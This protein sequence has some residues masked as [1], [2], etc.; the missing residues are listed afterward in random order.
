MKKDIIVAGTGCAGLI[1]ALA[2]ERKGAEVLLVD[3]GPL[4]IGSNSA[5][6]NGVF[7]GLG[8]TYTA[9]TYARDTIEIGKEINNPAYVD[10]VAK[11]ILPAIDVLRSHGVIVEESD[12]VFVVRP[13]RRDLARGIDLMRKLASAVQSRPGIDLLRGFSVT[14]II[15][16]GGRVAGITGIDMKGTERVMASSSVV[17][18]TG[19]AGAIYSRNDNQKKILGQSFRLAANAGCDLWDMEF[20]QFY[21]L[22]ICEP[23]LPSMMVYPPYPREVRLYNH[24]GEDITKK[25]GVESLNEL[26]RFKRDELSLL[27]FKEGERGPVTMDFTGVPPDG[28]NRYPLPFMEKMKFDFRRRPFVVSPGAHFFMGG[29]RTD[30]RGM[31]SVPGLFACGEA[32]WGLHGA[33]RRGG[34]ALTECIVSGMIAGRNATGESSTATAPLSKMEVPESVSLLQ[35]KPADLRELRGRIRRIAWEC[36]GVVRHE[37][38]LSRGLLELDEIDSLLK[39]ATFIDPK[40]KLERVDVEA[41]SLTLR[42]ILTASIERKESRGAFR[43]SDYTEQED[44]QWLC[45]SCLRYN[46]VDGTFSVS[47][48]KIE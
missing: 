34:N 20:V 19:G 33:N 18:A 8:K 26:I 37:E 2:A 31:T 41:A 7:A 45:N 48:H 3:R 24:L 40:E 36:G 25:H 39:K 46:R 21:P 42:A 30:D 11:G 27:I 16:E 29:I 22:V 38:G 44:A 12:G 28:W 5:M 10:I 47:H 14:K 23:T 15:V 35:F 13:G 9:E 4:G 43:R 6:A 17:L 32:V 1:A